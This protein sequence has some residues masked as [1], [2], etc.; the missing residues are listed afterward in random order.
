MPTL[1]R[2]VKKKFLNKFPHAT[3]KPFLYII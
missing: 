2:G 3:T 1:Y